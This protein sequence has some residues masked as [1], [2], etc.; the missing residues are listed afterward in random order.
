MLECGGVTNN[1]MQME[2]G[3]QGEVTAKKMRRVALSRWLDRNGVSWLLKDG[4]SS[5]AVCMPT[6]NH[7]PSRSAATREDIELFS[8]IEANLYTAV[9][10]DSLDELGYN[11]QAMNHY[12]RPLFPECLFAGW[13]RTI[14]CADVYHVPKDTYAT[15]IEAVD[16]IL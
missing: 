7:H 5:Y 15:E 8:H 3:G 14:S 2:Q 16:N 9:V 6:G 13:A 12:V 1:T 10:A 4:F 11:N